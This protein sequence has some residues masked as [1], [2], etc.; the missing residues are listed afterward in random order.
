MLLDVKLK[1]TKKQHCVCYC[2]YT[3]LPWWHF[4]GN[5]YLEHLRL[6]LGVYV[7]TD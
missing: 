4:I 2:A 5:A 3:V 7:L 6:I 1:L